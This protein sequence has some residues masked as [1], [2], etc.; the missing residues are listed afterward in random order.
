MASK[1]TLDELGLAKRYSIL[2]HKARREQ[3]RVYNEGS[4]SFSRGNA[5]R[6]RRMRTNTNQMRC[7]G[8]LI[9]FQK[10]VR[11]HGFSPGAMIQMSPTF[12]V[13]RQTKAISPHMLETYY[14]R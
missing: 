3:L 1:A 9:S 8:H 4:G 6:D 14:T 7:F 13:G 11:I 10:I 12:S 2:N 5:E